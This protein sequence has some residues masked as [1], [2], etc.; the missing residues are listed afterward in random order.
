MGQTLEQTLVR[1]ILEHAANFPWRLQDIG[2]L[3]LRLDDTREYRLHVWVPDRA[4]GDPPIHDHP[5]GFTSTVIVGELVNT[6]Y[7]EDPRGVEYLRERSTPGDD[8][9]RRADTVRL[10]GVP[11][12]LRPGD[13]Y[14]QSAHELHDSRQ[15]PGTV[16]ALRF[17]RALDDATELT[18]CRRPGA[19]WVSA[20]ARPATHDEVKHIT[21]AALARFDAPPPRVEQPARHLRQDAYDPAE[22]DRAQEGAADKRR[23]ASS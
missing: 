16:T 17:E 3:S 13:R 1:N 8:D 22:P 4:V 21:A 14:R 9:H 23:L 10:V 11:E 7:V 5:V 18:V 20:H 19:P 2:V 15:V 12:T 6:R